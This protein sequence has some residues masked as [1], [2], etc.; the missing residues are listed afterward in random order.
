M[1]KV[2]PRVVI[3]PER[4]EVRITGQGCCI[5]LVGLDAMREVRDALSNHITMIE[6]E[7]Y[8]GLPP[9]GQA[10]LAQ[11]YAE[12]FPDEDATR[13]DDEPTVELGRRIP[14]YDELHG[15][16]NDGRVSWFDTGSGPGWEVRES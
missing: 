8:G 3:D 1:E 16:G 14:T 13:G 10:T 2:P 7:R 5:V 4:D 9:V 6:S 15:S 12:T 11:A